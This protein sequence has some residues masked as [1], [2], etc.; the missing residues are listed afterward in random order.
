[1]Y[2]CLGKVSIVSFQYLIRQG[3]TFLKCHKNLSKLNEKS[4][5]RIEPKITLGH[6]TNRLIFCDKTAPN[7]FSVIDEPFELS[8]VSIL[9][10]EGNKYTIFMFFVH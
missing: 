10:L 3:D 5:L 2:V 9:C 7:I 8:K 4:I 6:K 1:M